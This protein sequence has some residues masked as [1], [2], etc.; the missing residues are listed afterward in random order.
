[1]KCM[2][3]HNVIHIYEKEREVWCG[4]ESTVFARHGVLN[5]WRLYGYLKGVFGSLGLLSEWLIA[6]VCFNRKTLSAS[7][8]TILDQ[9]K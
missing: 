8:F 2:L 1:M 3:F 5:T 4:L 6:G 7:R 9:M